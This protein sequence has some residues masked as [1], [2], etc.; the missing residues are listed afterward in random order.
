MNAYPNRAINGV[1]YSLPPPVSL[2]RSRSP[3]PVAGGPRGRD[4]VE[5]K[6]Q[7]AEDE[8]R[9]KLMKDL[10]NRSERM[11]A[12]L[13]D[14]S[15]Q[16]CQPMDIDA[17]A[18]GIQSTHPTSSSASLPVPP[19]RPARTIDEDDYGDDDE[20]DDDDAPQPPANQPK[21]A[22]PA[23]LEH[24][25]SKLH[26]LSA[27]NTNT[28]SLERR[29]E[30]SIGDRK[31]SSEDV[32]KK[33][34]EDRKAAGDS[35]KEN[36]L[37][38]FYT[39]EHDR[40]AMLEQQR[41]DDLDRQ[42]ETEMSGPGS[43]DGSSGKQ[44]RENQASLSKTNLGASSLTLKYLIKRIDAK[45]ASVHASDNDLRTLMTEVRKNRSKWASEDRIGQEELYEPAERVLMEL[46]SM[47]EYSQPFL[48][49][50]NKRE[51]PDYH[52]IIHN[53][54]DIGTMIKKL[55][56]LQ[57][58]SKSEFCKDLDQIWTNCFTYNKKPDNILHKKAVHLKAEAA[59]LTPLIPEIVVRD[60]AEVDAEERQAARQV[61]EDS[62]DDEPIVATRGRKAPSKKSKKG[63]ASAR[64]APPAPQESSTPVPEG[65]PN[66]SSLDVLGPSASHLRSDADSNADGSQYG[67]ATPPPLAGNSTPQ[68]AHGGLDGIGAT[69]H[70]DASE[71]DG[72]NTSMHGAASDQHEEQVEEDED[73]KTWKQVTKKD[74]A[75]AVAERHKLFLHE[76]RRIN[77]E[78]P[79]LLRT[80]AGM[81]RWIR[82]HQILRGDEEPAEFSASS[83]SN[84]N[85]TQQAGG[86]LAEGMDVDDEYTL[87]DYYD[88]VNGIPEIN[89]R[90][91]WTED[92]EGFVV[93]HR[94][95]CL[96][97]VPDGLFVSPQSNL[98]S[99]ME[100]NMRQMQ[101]SRKVMAKIGIVKQMQLQAQVRICIVSSLQSSLT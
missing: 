1:R 35:A 65:K 76:E 11:I 75:A 18:N 68:G 37:N 26:H 88:P 15:P 69:S 50:V 43:G 73:F 44:Q 12:K 60:K 47:T 5:D 25:P 94:E 13:F 2:K 55:K 66:S 39:L 40:D 17:P 29:P 98:T 56:Q 101:E 34:E 30:L 58:R 49:R 28:Y 4:H 96:R 6:D 61:E 33:L 36:F 91:R 80:R 32:R 82:Q 48:S 87:P 21:S 77:P 74:R 70:A 93:D 52:R 86:T 27:R 97:K 10:Y 24:T 78:E 9:Q 41:L 81:R 42:V 38:T 83:Q 14:K 53:P 99:K 84:E 23:A 92:S 67:T 95:E 64:K 54:M 45:R 46:K 59:K 19:N 57:Y 85:A 31:K 51:V 16:N 71:I 79:A 22:A 89:P 90:L 3:N 20:D 7:D 8:R 72:M 62:D 100:G 63:V